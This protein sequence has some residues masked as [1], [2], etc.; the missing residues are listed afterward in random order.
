MKRNATLV[1]LL[2]IA[3]LFGTFGLNINKTKEDIFKLNAIVVSINDDNITLI[4]KDDVI[5]TLTNTY[6]N[7]NI[8]DNLVIEYTGILN[9][10]NNTQNIEIVNYT[11]AKESQNNNVQKNY[12]DNGIFSAYYKMAYNKLQELSLDEKIGQLILARY[13]KENLI[14]DLEKYKLGGY[15]FFEKDFKNKSKTEVKEMINEVQ[16][17]SDIPLLIAVDE[18]GGKIVRVSSNPN[19]ASESFKSSKELYSQ[20]GME[21]IRKDTVN[22]SKMLSNLGI[23]LNLAP[24]VDVS[25]NPDDYMYERTIGE[26]TEITSLYAETVI[27][28]SKGLGVSYTLKH[29]PGYGNNIDTHIGSAIDNRSYEYILEHDIPPFKKGIDAGAEAVLVSH[30]IV[31][32]IDSNNPA[33]LSTKVHNLLRN[34]LE[35]TGVII[36]DDLYM[37]ATNEIDNAAVL[38]L[39]AGNNIIITTDY[40]D[41][42]NSIK[43]AVQNKII[44]E[45]LIDKLAFKVLA[46]KYYKGLMLDEK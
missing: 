15:I 29:F 16:N 18:E 27:K 38:A 42:F 19:L 21:A 41:D 5:Y 22:K 44:S 32:S 30:N 10:N 40:A 45:Q 33:S 43:D 25:T 37:G 6:N 12:Q 34:D 9:K 20:G 1:V 24:V 39:Q 46:W 36:T 8:G 13:P 14:E 3:L 31:N 23:N 7:V 4:D 28:A 35:F 26:S 17:N 2:I 11:I